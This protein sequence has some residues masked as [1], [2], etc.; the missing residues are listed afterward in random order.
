MVQET[1]SPEKNFIRQ[2]CAEGFISGIKG[3]MLALLRCSLF[4]CS[5]SV[6]LNLNVL[7]FI[8][9]IWCEECVIFRLNLLIFFRVV[10]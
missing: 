7:Y 1:K 4:M 2:C 9:D 6:S 10:M 5:T 8:K 3:L